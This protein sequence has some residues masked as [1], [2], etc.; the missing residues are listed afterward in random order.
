MQEKLIQ[1]LSHKLL[2]SLKFYAK[3][4]D[5]SADMQ[6]PAIS[7]ISKMAKTIVFVRILIYNAGSNL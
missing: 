4:L 5:C 2:E 3:N 7:V 1:Y 6:L